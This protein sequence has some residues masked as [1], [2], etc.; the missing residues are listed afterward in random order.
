MSKALRGTAQEVLGRVMGMAK[1][2]CWCDYK[3]HYRCVVAQPGITECRACCTCKTQHCS[4]MRL[5]NAEM[6]KTR[7]NSGAHKAVRATCM[8]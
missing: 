4:A 6:Q 3:P 2:S 5:A 1:A 7:A 8:P